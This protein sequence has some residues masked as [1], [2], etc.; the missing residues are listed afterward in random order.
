MS[1]LVSLALIRMVPWLFSFLLAT[2]SSHNTL[3]DPPSSSW[4]SFAWK[5][6]YLQIVCDCFFRLVL[7]LLLDFVS[8]RCHS[9]SLYYHFSM[10]WRINARSLLDSAEVV[11][12]IS[13]IT[14][15]E[16]LTFAMCWRKCFNWFA[17]SSL[18]SR[19]KV[20]RFVAENRHVR[21]S[22]SERT[23]RPWR[24]WKQRAESFPFDHL[25]Q[26]LTE[27]PSARVSLTRMKRRA[28]SRTF[29]VDTGWKTFLIDLSEC[30]QWTINTRT[31]VQHV[32][33]GG[34]RISD[35]EIFHSNE[36]VRI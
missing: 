12:W 35:V 9:F 14:F 34:V 32:W 2:G 6:N 13:P 33:I 21:R 23:P 30:L 15:I 36:I 5:L 19:V 20:R 31:S 25:E 7:L 17:S 18:R 1:S 3:L 22:P 28:F 24:E 16:K 10:H 26:P 8:C 27:F 4:F 29:H 11:K